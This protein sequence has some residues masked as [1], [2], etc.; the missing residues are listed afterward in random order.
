MSSFDTTFL[1]GLAHPDAAVDYLGGCLFR[2]SLAL[3][4]GAGV[5]EPLGAPLFGTLL[6]AG[7]A[8]LGEPAFDGVDSELGATRLSHIAEKKH[9]DLQEL[10]TKLLYPK[11]PPRP[12][13][14]MRSARMGALGAMLMGSKRGSVDTVLT[15]NYDS[16]LEEYLLLHGYVVNVVTHLPALIGSEDVT[17]FHP[18]GYLPSETGPG[19]ASLPEDL[20]FTKESVLNMLGDTSHATPFLIRQ[21]VRSK[22]LL[23]LGVSPG[24]AIGN[25]LGPILSHESS[26]IRADRPSAFWLG[27]ESPDA[28]YKRVLLTAN[29]VPVVLDSFDGIDEF[30]LSICRKAAEHIT[31]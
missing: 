16:L 31:L 29:V 19:R 4:L 13:D 11:G 26:G 28:D 7:L 9:V 25:S 2:G 17:V 6:N 22:V 21:I 30:L 18:H 14:L 8:H 20:V 3:L 15:L 27:A 5:S 1:E 24:T 10:L 12:S 23:L